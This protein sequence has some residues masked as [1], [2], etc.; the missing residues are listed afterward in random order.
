M[1][2]TKNEM[3]PYAKQFFYKLGNYLDTKI[4]Y[5]GSIQRDDFFPQ[6]SDI[7]ADIFT[8]NE[9]S[10]ITK[11]QNFLGVQKY[12][13]KNFIYRLHKT[14]KIVHGRKVKYDDPV[15]NFS[16]EISIYS[17]K[18]KNDVL[19]EHQSKMVLPFYVSYLLIFIKLLYYNLQILPKETYY[20]F[21]KIIMNYMVEGQDVEFIITDIS[22]SK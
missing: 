22:K 20:F 7:D 5:F 17:E 13:F 14:K 2:T 6:S 19:L 3:P 21:K 16:T 12:E 8:D 9:S 15:N 4:Y 11:L 10:T 1:E 18:D